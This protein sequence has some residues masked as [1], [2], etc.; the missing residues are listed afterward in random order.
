MS[1]HQPND[2]LD[3]VRSVLGEVLRSDATEFELA[4]PA[5]RL[6]VRR[7]PLNEQTSTPS[8]L[9]AP[10]AAE[11]GLFPVVAPLTGLFYAAPS[12][13][14]R[15]YVELGEWTEAGSI[16]GLIEAMKVFNEV[17]ADRSGIVVRLEVTDGTLVHAG[18]PL[19]FLDPAGAPPLGPERGR[20]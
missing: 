5:L 11:S 3:Q 10:E 19:I 2:W 7:R 16:V 12:P 6:R 14:A 1:P 13:S 9:A 17:T 8:T 4:Q 20:D 15:R 18:E